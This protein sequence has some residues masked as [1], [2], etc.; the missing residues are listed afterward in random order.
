[1][2][3]GKNVQKNYKKSFISMLIVLF[4]TVLFWTFASHIL[5]MILIFFAH[6]HWLFLKIFVAYT[7]CCCQKDT[8]LADSLI[9]APKYNILW[10]LGALH[11]WRH[12]FW[13]V[14]RPPPSPLSS[15]HLSATHPLCKRKWWEELIR[16]KTAYLGSLMNIFSAQLLFLCLG[17]ISPLKYVWNHGLG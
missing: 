16:D 1:M 9:F 3:T 2:E 14:S 15:C 4:I 10:L 5:W 17:V 11:K 13:G 8:W 6:I 7:L 12:H